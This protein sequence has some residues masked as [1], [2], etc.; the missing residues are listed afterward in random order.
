MNKENQ[1][2]Y[3][4]RLF[5]Q[6]HCIHDFETP[7]WVQKQRR[8]DPDKPRHERGRFYEEPRHAKAI[9]INAKFSLIAIGTLGYV[10]VSISIRY[11]SRK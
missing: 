6:G 2:E 8:I 5:W 7:K 10:L 1:P 3:L 4:S 11:L 9:A